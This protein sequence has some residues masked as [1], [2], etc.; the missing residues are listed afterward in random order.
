MEHIIPGLTMW[1]LYHR[2]E[3]E[4]REGQRIL[5]CLSYKKG[6]NSIIEQTIA[7]E[8]RGIGSGRGGRV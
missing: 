6:Q 8:Q 2:Y 4:H 3:G 7:L 1:I 5:K